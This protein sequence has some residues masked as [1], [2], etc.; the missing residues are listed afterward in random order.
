METR[1]D[2]KVGDHS[3]ESDCSDLFG[4]FAIENGILGNQGANQ[5]LDGEGDPA[6]SRDTEM[7]EKHLADGVTL[8]VGRLDALDRAE[9]VGELG[10]RRERGERDDDDV[11][12][13]HMHA[14]CFDC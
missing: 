10:E 7:L 8:H 3:K 11:H 6:A 14:S 4:G 5:R 2:I 9:D 12:E 13:V 1:R